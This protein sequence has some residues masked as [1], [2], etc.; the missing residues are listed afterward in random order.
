MNQLRM[1]KTSFLLIVTLLTIS[2]VSLRAQDVQSQAIKFGRVL[3]LIDNFYVDTT[4]ITKLT[5]HAI[6]EVLSSLDPHSV[7]ISKDEVAEM[8]QPLEG[9][10]EGIGI[11]FNIYLSRYLDG[12]DDN[13]RWPI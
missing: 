8:N 6:S 5:E 12:Y 13:S 2:H 7:Y 4:N 11:S 9:N 1:L 10:F 3:N